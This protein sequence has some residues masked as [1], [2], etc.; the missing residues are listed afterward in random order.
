MLPICPLCRKAEL[1]PR[2]RLCEQCR[3]YKRNLTFHRVNVK[4]GRVPDL[5]LPI[6]AR[7]FHAMRSLAE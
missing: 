6:P 3:I 5:P 4:R 7:T 2:K 1:P